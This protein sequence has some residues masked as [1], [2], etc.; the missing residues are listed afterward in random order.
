MDKDHNGYITAEE[1]AEM[2]NRHDKQLD[3]KDLGTL[4]MMKDSRK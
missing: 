1:I 3:F 4:V 2:F